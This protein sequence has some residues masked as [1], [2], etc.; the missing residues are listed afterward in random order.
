[1]KK[2]SGTDNR[3]TLHFPEKI[4]ECL[5]GSAPA[6]QD[7]ADNANI[8]IDGDGNLVDLHF[9]SEEEAV[10]LL[11]NIAFNILIVG[12]NNEIRVGKSLTA[13]Y[14]PGWG[15]FGLHLVIGTHFDA[16]MGT[17]RSANNCRL[18]LGE[19]VIVV[20]AMIFLL[21][22]DSHITIGNDTMI[23]W[24]IDI[25]CTDSHTITDMDG[26]PTNHPK[27]IEIGD[28]VWI[29]KNVKIGKNVRIGSNNIIGWGS[30]VTKSIEGENQLAV[31]TPAKVVKTGVRWD[32]RTIKEYMKGT[33]RWKN[34]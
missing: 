24:G 18:E 8:Q 6:W 1:M 28:H 19:H 29:G 31:G 16:W 12:N 34:D 13:C 17:P 9:G 10:A 7:L 33:G 11:K 23:S 20:G 15:A 2:I 32:G 5:D 22:D 4:V 30:T 27:F 25:W 14:T 26:N 21:E 3:L